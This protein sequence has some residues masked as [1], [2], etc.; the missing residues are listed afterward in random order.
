MLF[1]MVPVEKRVIAVETCDEDMKVDLM[2]VK[3]PENVVRKEEELM[4]LDYV[5]NEIKT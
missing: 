3:C 2:E 1:T 5:I 4:E